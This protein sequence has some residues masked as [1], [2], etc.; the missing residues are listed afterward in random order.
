VLSWESFLPQNAGARAFCRRRLGY[1]ES[2]M[3]CNR[4]F[5]LLLSL[6]FPIAANAAELAFEFTGKVLYGGTFAPVGAPVTGTFSYD[7]KTDPWF[8]Q[9]SD[10][11]YLIPAPHYIDVNV[12][13]HLVLGSALNATVSND[14]GGNVEDIVNLYSSGGAM[15]DGE[16][17]SEGTVGVVFASGPGSTHAL[18]NRRL[19]KR[20]DL[21]KFDQLGG[22]A[23]FILRDGGPDGYLVQFSIESVVARRICRNEPAGGNPERCVVR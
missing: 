10:A 20:Y 16:F 23:G 7:T 12:D 3:V 1:Q 9:G 4:R 17:M 6:L 18:H 22:N 15:L 11:F 19:P 13:G 8:E 21:D 2:V 5:A 14:F